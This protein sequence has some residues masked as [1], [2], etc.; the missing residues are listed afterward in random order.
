MSDSILTQIKTADNLPSL[1]AVALE[2]LRLTRDPDVPMESISDAIQRDPALTAKVLK[3]I[4]SPLCGM[5]REISSIT[6]AVNLLG[7]N[8]VKIMALSFSLVE[9]VSDTDA[10]ESFDYELFWRHSLTR[11][12]SARLIAQATKPGRKE[13]AFVGGLLADISML[14]ASRCAGETY[15]PILDKW[16][17]TG[18]PDIQDE[19]DSI[20]MSHASL[21]RELL[22]AWEIPSNLCDPIGA[23]H[24]ENID[25]LDG[26]DA[27]LAKLLYAAEQVGTLFCYDAAYAGI[28]DVLQACVSLTGIDDD[29]LDNLLDELANYV[30]ET[31]NVL[32]VNIGETVTYEEIREEV[33]QQIGTLD[34]PEGVAESPQRLAG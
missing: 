29:R 4:N 26:A 31:A 33:D 23:H 7:M 22:A 30:Q 27:E 2:I 8:A 15:N 18:L 13:D 21:S 32:A 19:I 3:M 6:Q 14:A 28:E 10:D 20:G 25:D 12:V 24:G 5:A 1:P 11:A 17:T 16:K 34:G 9:M